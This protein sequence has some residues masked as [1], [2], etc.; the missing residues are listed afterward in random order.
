VGHAP[1]RPR[2]PAR[3]SSGSTAAGWPGAPTAT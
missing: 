2:S 1:A 3:R